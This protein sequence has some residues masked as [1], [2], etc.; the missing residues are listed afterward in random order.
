MDEAN[1]HVPLSKVLARR[2]VALRTEHGLT[3]DDVARFARRDGLDW[4]RATVAS[5]ENGR[6]PISL[7]EMLVLSLGFDIDL[8][9]WFDDLPADRPVRLTE[10]PKKPGMYAD[11]APGALHAAF[12]ATDEGQWRA[13][14]CWDSPRTRPGTSDMDV[15][16]AEIA[17]GE[18]EENL[19]RAI[20]IEPMELVNR[21]FALWGRTLTEQRDRLVDEQ[22]GNRPP[23]S[24]QA[25]R[26][27]VTRQLLQE[28][29]EYGDTDTT[30]KTPEPEAG[31]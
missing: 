8:A 14:A 22:G 3:Q 26:G 31:P 5:I 1:P 12:V 27:H 15:L 4:S 10:N 9:D 25:R 24:I 18:A 28:L 21:S 16:R 20:G 11:I 2:L 30:A 13:A 23:T 7:G 19:A 29:Q 17:A 6:R